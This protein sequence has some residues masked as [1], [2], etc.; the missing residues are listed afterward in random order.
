[1]ELTATEKTILLNVLGIVI[2]FTIGPDMYKSE[3][4]KRENKV[5]DNLHTTAKAAHEKLLKL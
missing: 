2:N 3:E 5:F 4:E 1:M